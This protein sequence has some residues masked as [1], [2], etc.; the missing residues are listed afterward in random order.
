[1][2]AGVKPGLPSSPMGSSMEIVT[3]PWA[4]T[5][6]GKASH[7]NMI[8]AHSTSERGTFTAF[9]AISR[10]SI[11]SLAPCRLGRS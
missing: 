1:M 9:A 11:R 10:F 3:F 7:G 2:A 8:A 4:P 6:R 5:P